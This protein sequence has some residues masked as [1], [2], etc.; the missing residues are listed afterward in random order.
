MQCRKND[1]ASRESLRKEV[2]SAV[3][4]NAGIIC[5]VELIPQRGLPFTTSGK[6]IRSKAKQNWL[7]GAYILENAPSASNK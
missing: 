6:L 5:Q 7:D 3:S 4:R 1:P 2:L